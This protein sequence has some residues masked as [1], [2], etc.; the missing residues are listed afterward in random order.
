M[1]DGEVL[2]L[3]WA[4]VVV[5]AVLALAYLFTRY[6]AGRTAGGASLGRFKDRPMKL[7]AQLP[8]G[9]EQK[10]LLI[11]AGEQYY[12]LGAAQGGVTLLDKLSAEEMEK[13]RKSDE[14]DTGP[15]EKMG[16][17]EALKKVLEQRNGQRRS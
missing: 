3:I 9:R 15:G 10:V 13:L 4:L 2:Q 16:F 1:F 7:L 6:I 17:Q 5:A 12:L 14:S 11:Q 8:V